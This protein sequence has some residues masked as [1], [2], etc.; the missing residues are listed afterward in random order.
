MS[1]IDSPDY[2]TIVDIQYGGS[3]TDAPDWVN[4]VSGPGGGVIPGVSLAASNQPQDLGQIGWSQDYRLAE[5]STVKLT[6]GV[7][8]FSSV[9]AVQS[10]SVTGLSLFQTAIASG[11]TV[12]DC[13]M[14]LYDQDMFNSTPYAITASSDAGNTWSAPPSP[15][16]PALAEVSV[17]TP[18]A[19]TAGQYYAVVF[20][21]VGTTPP[22]FG[23]APYPSEF[24]GTGRYL[25][26]GKTSGGGHTS[27]AT[28]AFAATM[29]ASTPQIW[30]TLGPD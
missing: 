16:Y 30:A 21:A 2:T 9:Q 18:Y 12:A 29:E 1:S 24:V 23:A 15:G 13:W 11:L 20:L 10:V 27:L 5:S 8:Y 26:S 28:N 14:A 4:V 7:V 22:T 25:F 6:S 19:V 3:V 17:V